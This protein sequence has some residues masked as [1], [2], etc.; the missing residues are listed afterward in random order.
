M[1]A[2]V[3][4]FSVIMENRWIVCSSSHL[5]CD[6]SCDDDDDDDVPGAAADLAVVRR[7]QR[8][9]PQSGGVPH[10]HAFSCS[11]EE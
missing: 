7:D 3:G 8:R 6:D 1:K 2:L 10:R 5:T 4:A 11:Q 9:V